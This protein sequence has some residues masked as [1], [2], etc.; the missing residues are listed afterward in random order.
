[1][2]AI[3]L[4]RWTRQEYDRMIE[5]G[6]FSPGDRIQ[7]I[8]GEI[9]EMT[10]QNVLHAAGV[11]A[12]EEAMRRAFGDGF[13]IR[14]QFPLALG[15]DSEPEPDVAVVP[16]HWRDYLTSHP[17][18]AALVVEVSDS[19]LQFDRE[20]KARIYARAGIREYWIVSLLDRV[21]E[22]YRDP[23]PNGG[24]ATQNIV[25]AGESIQPLGRPTATI[26]AGEL[27]P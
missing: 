6:V 14:V 17:A 27:L 11:R 25:R 19:S 8:E 26:G 21:V 3:Q 9:I 12:A 18:T 16:G 24:Y 23:T 4:K 13:D 15:R 5:A 22:V 1:M 2:V 20:R 7:L 10:P